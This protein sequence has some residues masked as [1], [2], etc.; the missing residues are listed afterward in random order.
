MRSEFFDACHG[1]ATTRT[2]PGAGSFSVRLCGALRRRDGCEELP[3]QGQQISA[4]A[5]CEEAAETDPHKAAR[6]RVEQ[7]PPQKLFGCDGHQP[8]FVL[9]CIILPAESDFAVGKVHNP[10]IG[11]GDTV[12]VAGQIPENMFGAA[13]RGLCIDY[14]VLTE[15]RSK[16]GVERFRFC[17]YFMRPGNR[18]SPAWKSLLSP[19][20]NLPRNTRASTFTGRKNL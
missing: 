1:A 8:L 7:E 14:P 11:D 13:E 17:E 2:E 20:V 5:V 19:L 16:E 10:V 4:A 9:V 6:K 12:C 3:A 18:S 15:Q